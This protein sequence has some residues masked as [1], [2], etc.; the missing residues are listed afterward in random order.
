MIGIINFLIG[1]FLLLIFW[2]V[3]NLFFYA[4]SVLFKKAFFAIPYAINTLLTWVIQIYFILYP[5]YYIWQLVS[6]N[7]GIGWWLI[8]VAVIGLIFLSFI[9]YFWQM[10]VGLITFPI[11]GITVYFSQKAAEKLEKTE[12]E[13]DYEVLSPKGEVMSKYQSWGKTQKE[14]AKWFVVGYSIS[15][16]KQFLTSTSDLSVGF[17]WYV[18]SPMLV[19]MISSA[20]I[21]LVIVVINIIRR[22]KLVG[23]DKY[24]LITK[25]LK[26]SSVI[27]GLDLIYGLLTRI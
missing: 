12:E 10:I 6:A 1:Y 22:I 17:A 19:L 26:I 16:V 27:Y 15:F 9:M 21:A 7:L 2:F 13:F 5:L 24:L 25:S 18:I 14:L 11:G 23:D 8:V 3:F 4:L 20:V